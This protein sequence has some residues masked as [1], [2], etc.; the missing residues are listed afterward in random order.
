MKLFV[1]LKNPPFVAGN[2]I[3]EN[4][5]FLSIHWLRF[6]IPWASP[7]S[8]AWHF[9]AYSQSSILISNP[10]RNSSSFVLRLTIIR[11]VRGLFPF[12]FPAERMKPVWR[13]NEVCIEG[14]SSSRHDIQFIDYLRTYRV[15]RNHIHIQAAP[16]L[17]TVFSLTSVSCTR[18]PLPTPCS[19]RL[20]LAERHDYEDIPQLSR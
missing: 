6:R 1:H 4:Y 15:T 5:Y 8:I 9:K 13:I 17:S 12:E 18:P 2:A 14:I 19:F 7:Q 11:L 20:R 3:K 16:R 10:G